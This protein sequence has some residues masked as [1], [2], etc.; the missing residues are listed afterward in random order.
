MGASLEPEREPGA[1]MV[2][3]R[4][5]LVAVLAMLIVPACGTSV[6]ET[7]IDGP[8][9]TL[10]PRERHSVRIY[11]SGPPAQPHTD[12]AIL[13]VEQSHGLNEQG[14]D[15]MLDRLRTR[16]AQLGC[17]GVVVGGMR[18][19]DGFP[20]G[21]AFYLLDPGA[22]TLHGTCIVFKGQPVARKPPP[23]PSPLPAAPAPEPSLPRPAVGE[24]CCRPP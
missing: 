4:R 13:Q 9:G 1:A 6:T 23:P 15:I 12:V 19:R 16:A 2:A 8:P 17:D 22:T 18:E 14:L 20:A 3:A 10:A 7:Y 11:A 24:S 5:G 21:T